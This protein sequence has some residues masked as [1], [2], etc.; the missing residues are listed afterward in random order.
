[1]AKKK[2]QG[3]VAAMGASLK[4]ATWGRIQCIPM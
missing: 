2:F 1:M 4:A 3:N